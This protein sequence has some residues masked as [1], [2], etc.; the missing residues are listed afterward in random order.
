[1]KGP[2]GA[3]AIYYEG[4]GVSKGGGRPGRV[5]SWGLCVLLGQAQSWRT[6]LVGHTSTTTH[7]W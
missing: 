3:G 2:A 1:M 6:Q 5:L 7:A 4:A